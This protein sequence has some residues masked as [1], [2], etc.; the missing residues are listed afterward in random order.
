[1]LHSLLFSQLGVNLGQVD[2]CTPLNVTMYIYNL[3]LSLFFFFFVSVHFTIL[4]KLCNS[5]SKKQL[6]FSFQTIEILELFLENKKKK[7]RKMLI[8][9]IKM[10]N[11][12]LYFQKYSDNI[13][14]LLRFFPFCL[15][16]SYS[17]MKRVSFSLQTQCQ[18]FWETIHLICD[19]LRYG[20][21]CGRCR[22]AS[23]RS[24]D[25]RGTFTVNLEP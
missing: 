6:N 11:I 23:C 9:K 16:L 17:N 5:F 7:E 14:I 25:W 22:K 4:I 1:M 19:Y 10:T 3:V 21:L 20:Q 15:S 2:L 8:N 12:T 24:W 13:I 18:E